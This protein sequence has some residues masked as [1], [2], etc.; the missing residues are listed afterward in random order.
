MY[1]DHGMYVPFLRCRQDNDMVNG[2]KLLN[3]SMSLPEPDQTT[4]GCITTR[5]QRDSLLKRIEERNV[6][7]SGQ[8][9]YK[10]VWYVPLPLLVLSLLVLSLLGLLLLPASRGNIID[11][12]SRFVLRRLLHERS[13]IG[14]HALEKDQSNTRACP[15]AR[16]RRRPSY[17]AHPAE[18]SAAGN[19]AGTH[20]V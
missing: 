8:M 16:M 3:L 18:R 12:R 9:H 4:A 20:P 7:R 17:L 2:T 11:S 14:C 13:T 6:I 10:G 5:G 1:D 19:R 15:S